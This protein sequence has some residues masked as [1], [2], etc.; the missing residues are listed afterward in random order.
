MGLTICMLA[1]AAT[2][3][4]LCVL[5]RIWSLDAEP[6]A[7]AAARAPAPPPPEDV[8]AELV[9]V[10]REARGRVLESQ[11]YRID[12]ARQEA[13]LSIMAEVRDVR[14]RC[15]AVDWQLYEDV[16][17]PEGWVEIWTVESWTDHLREAMRMG[18]ADRATLARAAAFHVGKPLPPSRYLAVAPHRLPVLRPAGYS[19]VVSLG[20]SA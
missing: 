1:A 19:G 5:T 4:A 15:G 2:G 3:F 14:G 8:A 13:F 12:P 6:A 11:H 18:A 7:E 9:P 20:R 17:H 16:A 10:V